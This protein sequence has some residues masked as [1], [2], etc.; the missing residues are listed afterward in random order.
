MKN[1]VYKNA[2]FITL[3]L[4]MMAY[5]LNMIN[6]YLYSFENM[7]EFHVAIFY[8]VIVFVLLLSILTFIIFINSFKLSNKYYLYFTWLYLVMFVNIL[9]KRSPIFNTIDV[10]LMTICVINVIVLLFGYFQKR[11]QD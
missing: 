7:S 11:N 4:I 1:K 5:V 10:K 2:I 6:F 9:R 3:S 8:Y